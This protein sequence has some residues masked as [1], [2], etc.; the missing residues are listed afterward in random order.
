MNP[1]EVLC[2]ESCL[3]RLRNTLSKRERKKTARKEKGKGR[4]MLYSL[5]ALEG[6]KRGVCT[7]THACVAGVMFEQ[8]F[9]IQWLIYRF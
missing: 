5:G 8:S 7:H 3:P 6:C 1:L 4:V 9:N 2:F